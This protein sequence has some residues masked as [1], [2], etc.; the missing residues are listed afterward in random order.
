MFLQIDFLE[1]WISQFIPI[2]WN[3]LVNN[4]NDNNSTFTS[5]CLYTKLT[6]PIVNVNNV[7]LTLWGSLHAIATMIHSYFS[8]SSI[9]A[10]SNLGIICQRKY[11]LW[12]LHDTGLLATK[13]LMTTMIRS[14]NLITQTISP[15]I[16]PTEYMRLIWRLF[17]LTTANLDLSYAV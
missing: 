3:Y 16:D 13:P 5:P 17:Y 14:F 4:K 1:I 2:F 6:S 11:T 12:L 15:S 9:Q 10:P 8:Q 7:F